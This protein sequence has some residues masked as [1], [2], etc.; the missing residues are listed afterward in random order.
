MGPEDIHQVITETIWTILLASAPV[1]AVAMLVGLG[2][3]AVS[4]SD[5]DSGDDTDLRAEGG[6]DLR[7]YRPHAPVHLYHPR[8]T[9]RPGVRPDH[10][11]QPV[12]MR[13]SICAFLIAAAVSPTSGQAQGFGGL[14]AFPDEAPAPAQDP[15]PVNVAPE[16]P[17]EDIQASLEAIPSLNGPLGGRLPGLE[18]L[19][20]LGV[21]SEEVKAMISRP[22]AS[23]RRG[24]LADRH[25]CLLAI[26]DAER[27]HGIPEDLL[28][29][30]GLQEAGTRRDGAD[31]VWPWSVNVEGE[32]HVFEDRQSAESFV[33]AKLAE[34]ATSIDV[35]CMQ[36]N[37][38]W[39][40]EAFS[41]PHEGFDPAKNA[42]YAARFLRK[43][44][45][46]ND[47]WMEAVGR[48][49]SGTPEL[50][51]A[52]AGAVTAKLPLARS[53][54]ERIVVMNTAA[55]ASTAPVEGGR[56]QLN[57][58]DAPRRQPATRKRRYQRSFEVARSA[59][60]DSSAEAVPQAA[61]LNRGAP[62]PLI[63]GYQISPA[64]TGS[65]QEN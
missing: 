64:R 21:D 48:Y 10:Q 32:G 15:V 23:P 30:V 9:V 45:E 5:L 4:G 2:D 53:L 46:E 63:P 14:F 19:G 57:P 59:S 58:L 13:K 28:L 17:Q 7:V 6:R 33:A 26:R 18:E 51:K 34:G 29:A 16:V 3:R 56:R 49:H 61:A 36:V 43:L 40:P 35:G 8:Q 20:A 38:R 65:A 24:S 1:L 54:G 52:Y 11:R 42:D 60:P 39:H 22:R 12:I 31:T 50:S 44:Y 55:Q 37:L 27:A 47:N 25:A 41:T 62:T